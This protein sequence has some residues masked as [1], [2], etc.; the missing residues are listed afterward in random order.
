MRKELG[1]NC[2]KKLRARLKDLSAAA[3]MEEIPVGRPHTLRGDFEGCMALDLD[4]GRR[5]VFEAADDPVP[6][7]EDGSIDWASVTRVR[8]VYI[9]DYH[10]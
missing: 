7:D 9:G 2:A 6:R 10:D 1:H 4:R 5:L 8:I 3:N